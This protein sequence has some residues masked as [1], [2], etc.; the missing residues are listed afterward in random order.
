MLKGHIPLIGSKSIGGP[1][2]DIVGVLQLKTS[3]SALL[4][5]CGPCTRFIHTHTLLSNER[6]GKGFY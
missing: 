2:L 1:E 4:Q 3:H 5:V 6:K